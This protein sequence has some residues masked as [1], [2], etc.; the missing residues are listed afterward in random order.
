LSKQGTMMWAKKFDV[1]SAISGNP[2][3]TFSSDGYFY[4]TYGLQNLNEGRTVLLKLDVNGNLVFSRKYG[5]SNF[6]QYSEQIFTTNSSIYIAGEMTSAAYQRD[7][8]LYKISKNGNLNWAKRLHVAGTEEYLRGAKQLN[9]DDI[10][11]SGILWDSTGGPDIAM[12]LYRLDTNGVIQWSKKVRT[13]LNKEV[14]GDALSEDAQGSIYVGGRIDTIAPGVTFGLWDAFLMKFGP[15]GN[16]HWAKYYGRQDYDETYNVKCTSDKGF[17][18]GAEP[19]S[20]DSVSRISLIKMDSLGTIE[21]MKLY[22]KKTGGFANEMVINK[23]KGYTI[24]AREGD[25]SANNNVVFIRTD[26]L[27]N[28]VCPTKTVSLLQGTFAPIITIAG[29]ASNF[30]GTI[31]YTPT[32]VNGSFPSVDYCVVDLDNEN[33]L[34]SVLRIYPNPN[35]GKFNLNSEMELLDGKMSV[36]NSLGEI[37]LE[38]K[39]ERGMNIIELNIAPGLYHIRICE[40]GNPIAH[41]KIIIE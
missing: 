25:Y 27:G 9:N 29:G 28:S 31:S 40:K 41:G 34:N 6:K 10:L 1:D 37:I 16:F 22:G 32:V 24:I 18:M 20:F 8:F 38:Q 3:L 15:A 36:V 39:I 30:S 21:W 26:S 13:S 7:I 23:D 19:E 17:I 4:V 5:N 33:K 14:N 2:N 11:V 35:S 12:S